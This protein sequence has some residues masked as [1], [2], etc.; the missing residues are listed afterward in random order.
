MKTGRFE[1]SGVE[2]RLLIDLMLGFS[3]ESRSRHASLP[4]R[5]E[6]YAKEKA[7]IRTVKTMAKIEARCTAWVVAVVG[8]LEAA[9]QALAVAV[10]D[11]VA[12]ISKRMRSLEVV[13]ESKE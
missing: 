5:K 6:E 13:R 9:A 2:G 1:R 12:F 4:R 8:V 11:V 7:D 3:S 10:H